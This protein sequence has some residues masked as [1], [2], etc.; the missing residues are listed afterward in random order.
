MK[1]RC[2]T[3]MVGMALVTGLTALGGTPAGADERGDEDEVELEASL[4]GLNE[5]TPPGGDAD[6][7]GEAEVE[8]KG[9]EVCWEIEVANIATV[10]GAHIHVGAIGANGGVVV[11]FQGQLQGCTTVSPGL[12]T[13]LRNTPQSYYVNVHNAAF[14]G[15]AVRGQM[16]N[17]A[18]EAEE[19]EFKARLSGAAER[20]GPGDPDGSGK[21]RAELEGTLLCWKFEEENVAPITARHIHFAP[22]DRAGP[23]V[24]SFGAMARGCRDITAELAA[25][26]VAKPA[27]YYVNSHNRTYPPGAVR[28]QL[29]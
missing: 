28:G 3:L 19:V 24:V 17:K 13:A 8:V 1:K 25:A 15:G 7:T 16:R 4:S 10:T 29:G 5:V 21:F 18:H 22:A 2:R 27:S 9:T 23:V 14:P 6:G 20:P 26:I 12:A 11:N